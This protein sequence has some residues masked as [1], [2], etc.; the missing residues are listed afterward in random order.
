MPFPN[1][2]PASAPTVFVSVLGA[3][4]FFFLTVIPFASD[5]FLFIEIF[6]SS[7]ALPQRLCSSCLR[8]ASSCLVCCG[9]LDRK[10]TTE[11]CLCQQEKRK[12]RKEKKRKTKTSVS[13]AYSPLSIS[14]LDLPST[15]HTKSHQPNISRHAESKGSGCPKGT[16]VDGRCWR[17]ADLLE[18]ASHSPRQS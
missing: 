2:Q 12:E 13:V 8:N 10:I 9:P 18:V 5:L 15:V 4:F 7:I 3:F 16:N 1:D 17:G 14:F 6:I 11:T